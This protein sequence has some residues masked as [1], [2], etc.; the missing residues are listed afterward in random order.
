MARSSD[1]AKNIANDT[2]VDRTEKSRDRYYTYVDPNDK[3]EISQSVDRTA[4]I[5][6]GR[7]SNNKK[8]RAQ[9][10]QGNADMLDYIKPVLS[11]P[12]FLYRVV[13]STR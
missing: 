7:L 6:F 11:P 9:T 10:G 2:S 3:I 4:N 5:A 8:Y 12:P 13:T 1:R